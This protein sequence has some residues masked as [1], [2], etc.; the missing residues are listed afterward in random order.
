MN[1]VILKTENAVFQF[2][3]DD[4][5]EHLYV[6]ATEYE[7]DEALSLLNRIKIPSA[8]PF[9]IHEEDV[10]FEYIVVD[11]ITAG[12][13]SVI[14]IVCDKTYKANQLKPIKVGHGKSPFDVNPGMK[15]GEKSLFIQ[16]KRVPM[17]G[18]GGYQ[19][20][21]GHELISMITWRT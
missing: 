17:F 18:G 9:T 12:K 5:K 2:D 4:V 11:L 10:Y 13:G 14:C 3:G 1:T 7:F 19:C 15:G 6:L 21:E 20:P 8:D 16:K